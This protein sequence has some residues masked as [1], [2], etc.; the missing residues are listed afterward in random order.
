MKRF[1]D[2]TLHHDIVPAFCPNCNSSRT[3]LDKKQDP[4]S[5]HVSQTV[6]V[7]MIC[8]GCGWAFSIFMILNEGKEP[9]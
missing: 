5:L 4:F 9:A 7:S 2:V 8:G 3:V 6:V 1:D